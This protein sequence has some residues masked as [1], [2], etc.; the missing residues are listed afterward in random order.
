MKN[1]EPRTDFNF[2]NRWLSEFGAIL[3][4]ENKKETIKI[5]S[6]SIHKVRDV[7]DKRYYTGKC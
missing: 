4:S 3:Y 6:E 1:L 5:L 2:N 7:G